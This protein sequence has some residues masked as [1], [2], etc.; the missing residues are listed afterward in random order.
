MKW[1]FMRRSGGYCGTFLKCHPSGKRIQSVGNHYRN[2]YYECEYQLKTTRLPVKEIAF[3]LGFNNHSFF[4][5]YF[6]KKGEDDSAGISREINLRLL[7]I[8]LYIK[9]GCF[10]P[11]PLLSIRAGMQEVDKKSL[12]YVSGKCEKDSALLMEDLLVLI[13]FQ[14]RSK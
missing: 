14:S 6:R 13:C 7:K 8:G 5:K 11:S 12:K 4:N 10:I 1:R 9:M 3:S 2:Y